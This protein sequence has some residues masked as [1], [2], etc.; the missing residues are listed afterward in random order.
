MTFERLKAN[1][2][3]IIGKEKYDE[4]V[5][6]LT[7]MIAKS[8]DREIRQDNIKIHVVEDDR[9]FLLRLLKWNLSSSAASGTEDR[10]PKRARISVELRPI[11]PEY[12]TDFPWC[13]EDTLEEFDVGFAIWLRPLAP[14][15]SVLAF[16]IAVAG[17]A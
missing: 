3:A 16:L 5:S 11:G 2:V 4:K 9:A 7:Y 15:R 17:A 1:A 12:L 6:A 14:I 8:Y 10:R 13:K